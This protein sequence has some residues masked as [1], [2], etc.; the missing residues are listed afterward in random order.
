M[1][2]SKNVKENVEIIENGTTLY[3]N[4]L[5]DELWLVKVCLHMSHKHSFTSHNSPRGELLHKVVPFFMVLAQLKCKIRKQ[6]CPLLWLIY[7]C[8]LR[9]QCIYIYI[10]FKNFLRQRQRA[11]ENKSIV[12]SHILLIYSN[13][14]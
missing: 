6:Y 11:I 10:Y 4:S 7:E 5:R 9:K 14:C 13:Q 2:R 8:P 1:T 3:H 12:K